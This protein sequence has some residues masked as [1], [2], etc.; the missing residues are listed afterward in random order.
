MNI[1]FYG[2]CQLRAILK[3]LNLSHNYNIFIFQCWRDHIDQQY[4][5][6]IIKKCDIII[7]QSISDNYRN[8]DYL[9]TLY[10]KQH[11]KSNCKLIIFDSCYFDFYYFDLTYKK[12]NNSILHDS[13]GY[14]YNKMIEC[15][16]NEHSID[17]YIDNFVN[18]LDFSFIRFLFFN[19]VY[20]K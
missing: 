5:T 14:H 7:T 12:F 15:Y 18:N 19:L 4:F 20:F 9:S 2:N 3:T 16:N 8:V 11:K 17:Y 1:L 6:D 10:I 13:I